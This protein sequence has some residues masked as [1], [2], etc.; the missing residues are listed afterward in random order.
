MENFF[1]NCQVGA[2]MRRF[3]RRH[4]EQPAIRHNHRRAPSCH[5]YRSIAPIKTECAE[6]SGLGFFFQIPVVFFD[7]KKIPNE[8]PGQLRSR[9]ATSIFAIHWEERFRNSGFVSG[10]KHFLC[11]LQNFQI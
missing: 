6:V 3:K 2:D 5:H 11:F 4:Q 10:G 7:L 9:M 8:P 1:E